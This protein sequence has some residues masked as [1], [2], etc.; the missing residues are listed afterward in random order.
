MYLYL[1][2]TNP[3]NQLTIIH[4]EQIEFID[5]MKTDLR[6]L[7]HS[8]IGV[9]SPPPMFKAFFS[10]HTILY[11]MSRTPRI[12]SDM[13][14]STVL[15][16]CLKKIMFGIFLCSYK[17]IINGMNIKTLNNGFAYWKRLRVVL[18]E[19][20]KVFQLDLMVCGLFIGKLESNS[21]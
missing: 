11:T 15:R 6:Y 9:A 17:Q 1:R 20:R 4:Y 12:R 10:N 14:A 5:S 13:V 7:T 8:R 2:R 21:R 3:H 16:L 18:K 19:L